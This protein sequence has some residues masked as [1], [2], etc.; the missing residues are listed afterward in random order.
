MN[1]Q[2]T[3]LLSS[4]VAL[5]LF[6]PSCFQQSGPSE[7]LSKFVNYR[8]SQ[9]QTREKLLEMTSGRLKES[10]SAM[11]DETFKLFVEMPIKKKSFKIIKAQCGELQCSISYLIKYESFQQGKKD[12]TVDSKKIAILKKEEG[13]WK[14]V[15]VSNIK[16]YHHSKNLI[17]VIGQ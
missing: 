6:I 14:I 5:V 11:S 2:K 10:I 7:T 16:G 17:R 13:A 4:M 1:R 3:W 8:F 9:G 12:F 15:E